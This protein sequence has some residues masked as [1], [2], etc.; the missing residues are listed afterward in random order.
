MGAYTGAPLGPYPKPPVIRADRIDP[1]TQEF[2]SLFVDRDP[3]D[4]AVVEALWRVKGS[5]AAVAD[6]GTRYLDI[7]KIDDQHK[8]TVESET[9]TAL[10]RLVKRGDISII[11]IEVKIGPDW[12]EVEVTYLNNRAKRDRER[13]RRAVRRLPEWVSDGQTG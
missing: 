4:A 1:Q 7:E 3:T 8:R 10:H 2:T 9:E 6:V 13:E 5:G 12:S 11:R